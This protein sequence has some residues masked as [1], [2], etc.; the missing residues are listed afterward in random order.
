MKITTINRYTNEVIS[1]IDTDKEECGFCN[2]RYEVIIAENEPVFE[3]HNG[4]IYLKQNSFIVNMSREE[5]TRNTP[6]V[7]VLDKIREEIKKIPTAPFAT[8]YTAKHEALEII[9]RYK[10]GEQE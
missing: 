3:N 2:N 9:D 1:S 8:A 5:Q 10:E 4:T 7:D 6:I